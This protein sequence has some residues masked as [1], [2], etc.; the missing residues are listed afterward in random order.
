MMAMSTAPVEPSADPRGPPLPYPKDFFNPLNGSGPKNEEEARTLW[1]YRKARPSGGLVDVCPVGGGFEMLAEVAA[2]RRSLH[3]FVLTKFVACARTEAE[4]WGVT[5]PTTNA[6]VVTEK[7]LVVA[8]GALQQTEG[9]RDAEQK[10]Y[11]VA[12]HFHRERTW[13]AQVVDDWCKEKNVT[14]VFPDKRGGE[15]EKLTR[16]HQSDR[17]GF[18]VV[19]R[20]A[21]S[22]M[23]KRLMRGMLSRAHWCIARQQKPA[24]AGPQYAK[25]AIPVSATVWETCYIVNKGQHD[26][27]SCNSV[28]VITLHVF[29]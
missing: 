10:A 13:L 28:F 29:Y 11:M 18:G 22:Q 15:S 1:Q 4:Q 23:V 19:A 5:L 21:K 2:L 25:I 27:V 17:G 12:F 26:V 3:T 6:Q 20:H 16:Q 7:D 8:L 24:H 9:S 14:I